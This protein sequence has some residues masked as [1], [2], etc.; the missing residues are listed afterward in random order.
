VGNFDR[1]DPFLRYLR[2]LIALRQQVKSQLYKSD[3][4]DEIGLGPMPE[5]VLAKL[6]RHRQG[7]SMTIN[8]IDRR[9]APKKGFPLTVDLTKHDLAAARKA[10]LYQLGGGTSQLPMEQRNGKLTL[11]IPPLEGEA[12]A[13]VIEL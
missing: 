7:S 2:Q 9:A 4:R 10:T 8:L 13:I 11:D 6:F 5:N 1:Q 3:F 12:A